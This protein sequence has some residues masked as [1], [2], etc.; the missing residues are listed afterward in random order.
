MFLRSIMLNFSFCIVMH[1]ASCTDVCFSSLKEVY[2]VCRISY[3]WQEKLK[4]QTTSGITSY[5]YVLERRGASGWL[6][7]PSLL[8]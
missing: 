2:L 1:D 3:G 6:K 8:S 4:M 5:K 7:K